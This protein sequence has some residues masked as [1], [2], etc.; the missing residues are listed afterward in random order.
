MKGMVLLVMFLLCASSVLGFEKV[1]TVTGE[2]H[3]LVQKS[4]GSFY[5]PDVDFK[6]LYS[7][8]TENGF[9]DPWAT[10]GGE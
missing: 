1:P 5:Q 2:P 9:E 8:V 10:S 6:K 7:Q 3:K 4:D